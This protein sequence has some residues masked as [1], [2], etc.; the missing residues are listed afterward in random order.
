MKGVFVIGADTGAGK[1][2]VGVALGIYLQ[3][4]GLPIKVLKPFETGCHRIKRKLIPLDGTLYRILLRLE[5]PIEAIVPFRYSQPLAPCQS[6]FLDK[7][8]LKYAKAL[9]IIQ[10]YLRG[11]HFFLL[12]GAGGVLV[13]L[14]ERIFNIDL[15]ADLNLPTL[16]VAPNRLGTINHT[17]LTLEALK[18]RGIKTAGVILN[19]LD[20]APAAVKKINREYFQ[21]YLG[22]NYLGEFPFRPGAK[23]MADC[24]PQIM[25]GEEP[26]A[27]EIAAVRQDLADSF[28]GAVNRGLLKSRLLDGADLY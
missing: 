3:E 10:N 15:I 4:A 17:L 1:T 2:M 12:E 9:P 11:D 19:D 8:P 13:P 5:E 21:S 26:S 18:G 27:E 20:G 24:L 28:S 16:L 22:E 23:E 7:K 14:E 25:A 6:S